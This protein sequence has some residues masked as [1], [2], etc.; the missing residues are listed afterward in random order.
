MNFL[1]ISNGETS[2]ACLFIDKNLVAACSEERFT[3]KKMDNT[4]PINSIKYCLKNLNLR[5][6]DI[7]VISYAWAKGYQEDIATQNHKRLSLLN[8]NEEKNIFSERI[9]SEQARDISKRD[10]FWSWIEKQDLSKNTVVEDFYHHEAH[11]FSAC[12]MSN[13]DSCAVLTCDGRG[14]YESL[15]FSIFDK[16]TQKLT[17]LFSS[18]SVDSL[19][20]FYGRITG[21]LGY[22]PCRHEGKITG[23]AAYSD[24]KIAINLM[25]KM[26]NF[27][28]DEIRAN[29][30]SYYRPFYKNYDPILVKEIQSFSKEQ[31]SA[32]AQSHLEECLTSLV[33]SLFFKHNLPKMALSIAGG[34]FGNVKVNQKL[35]ELECITKLFVQPQ[36]GDGGLAIGAACG[37]L[38]KRK[39]EANFANSMALGPIGGNEKFIDNLIDKNA[40]KYTISKLSE[41][42]LINKIV[43][44]LSNND[45]VGLV[46][47][48][49]EFGP[50]ALC[51]RSILYK[52]SD[53]TCNDWLNKRMHRNEF[54]PFGP[55]MTNENASKYL[56]NY[57]ENDISLKFMTCTSNVKNEFAKLCPAVTHV[58]NTARPQVVFKEV[59]PWL[60]SLLTKW[61]EIS[62]E[63]SL[64]NTSFNQHEEPI[65]CS[66]DEAL[67][68][69]DN[70]TVDTLVL[71]SVL[72]KKKVSKND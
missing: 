4:F 35:K 15:T 63:P 45:V 7:D 26:I 32:A 33:K 59:D 67:I 69:L 17:K 18:N 11:A 8:S 71:D 61:K 2:S 27:D 25:K 20:F 65:I 43:T 9:K 54:M 41:D 51:Q 29:L 22:T 40:D 66:Y 60:W 39:M 30:G 53:K 52:T 37:S 14:D 16:K 58:D 62:G 72:I 10:E 57:E 3:R 44:N 36:M 12:S 48:R 50:R 23:L 24:P 47:G 34:V 49:M 13:F 6:T 55:V 64:I 70:G 56:I 31:I 42:D 21:L 28:G 1:G 68:N 38:S 46:R 19:G 5:L